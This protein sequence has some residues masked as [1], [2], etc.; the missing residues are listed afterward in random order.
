MAKAFNITSASFDPDGATGSRALGSPM[1]ARIAIRGEMANDST[2]VDNFVSA[3]R[4]VRRKV[5]IQVAFND[6]DDMRVIQSNSY[7]GAQGTLTIVVPD[8]NGAAQTGTISNAI[9]TEVVGDAQHAEF[10]SHIATFEAISTDGSTNPIS[11]V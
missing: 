3:Q 4:L 2:G 11:W 5:F 8:V 6:H 7:L 10:G 1:S 9:L